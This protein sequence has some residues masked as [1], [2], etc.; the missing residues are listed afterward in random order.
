MFAFSV[1][2]GLLI[3]I[4]FP[5]FHIGN[6]FQKTGL[7]GPFLAACLPF[8]GMLSLL[9]IQFHRARSRV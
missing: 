7:L 8:V 1:A 2:L 9:S 3:L 4:Y 5:L 6:S